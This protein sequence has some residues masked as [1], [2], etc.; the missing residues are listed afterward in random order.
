M[1]ASN[2]GPFAME[3]GESYI[4]IDATVIAWENPAYNNKS[5]KLVIASYRVQEDKIDSNGELTDNS[6]LS[7]A[8]AKADESD[9]AADVK[10]YYYFHYFASLISFITCRYQKLCIVQYIAVKVL[11]NINGVPL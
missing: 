2:K 6:F 7:K 4:Q 1:F 8:C 10:Q 5:S 9:W 11:G 3:N